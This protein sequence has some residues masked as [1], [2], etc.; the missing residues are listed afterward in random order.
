[1]LAHHTNNIC[2]YNFQTLR[3]CHKIGETEV[4][5]WIGVKVV[6]GGTG[7]TSVTDWAGVTSVRIWV[8]VT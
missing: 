3:T 7:V 4:S 1:M 5:G 6:S 2:G 8:G